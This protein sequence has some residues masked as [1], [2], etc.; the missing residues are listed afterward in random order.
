[1]SR[2]VYELNGYLQINQTYIFNVIILEHLQD[3]D[4]QI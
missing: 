4:Y 3:L 1:M 2:L